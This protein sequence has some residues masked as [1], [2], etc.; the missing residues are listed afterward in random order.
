MVS[1]A[2]ET[3]KFFLCTNL[4]LPLPIG[5]FPSLHR[6]SDGLF[7]QNWLKTILYNVKMRAAWCKAQFQHGG[8]FS[9]C[10]LKITYRNTFIYVG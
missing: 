3:H 9:S 4:S 5:F 8:H 6:V 2:H 10:F 7:M 1:R